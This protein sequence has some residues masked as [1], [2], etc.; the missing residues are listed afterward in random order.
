MTEKCQGHWETIHNYPL[1]R[2]DDINQDNSNLTA[3]VIRTETTANS[4]RSSGENM[5]VSS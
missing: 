1:Y 2:T 5:R 4:L 3:Y